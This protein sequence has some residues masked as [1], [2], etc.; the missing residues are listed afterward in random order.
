MQRNAADDELGRTAE[1]V[2][3]RYGV[4]DGDGQRAKQH[5]SEHAFIVQ[6][7]LERE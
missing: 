6:L 4:G 2:N 1:F 5:I 3:L 7:A